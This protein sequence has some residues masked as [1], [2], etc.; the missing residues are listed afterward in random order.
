MPVDRPLPQVNPSRHQIQ[1]RLSPV[2]SLFVSG[3][4]A[5]RRHDMPPI[6]GSVLRYCTTAVKSSMQKSNGVEAMVFVDT[7]H[8]NDVSGAVGG[9]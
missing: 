2:T 8:C 9:T 1:T 6:E 5:A 3:S 4:M 7:C